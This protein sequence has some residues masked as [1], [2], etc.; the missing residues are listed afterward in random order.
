MKCKACGAKPLACHVDGNMKCVGNFPDLCLVMFVSNS[1]WQQVVGERGELFALGFLQVN[2]F[3]LPPPPLKFLS[4]LCLSASR[5]SSHC[6]RTARFSV[7]SRE[8]KTVKIQRS[9]QKNKIVSR[10]QLLKSKCWRKERISDK[11]L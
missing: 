1:M 9:N 5:H 6:C 7:P 8:R 3:V 4:P 10:V 2:S 11:M